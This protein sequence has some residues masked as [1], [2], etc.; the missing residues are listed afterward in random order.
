MKIENKKIC[1]FA[2]RPLSSERNLIG[3]SESSIFKKQVCLIS[4]ASEEPGS[5]NQLLVAR[6][7]QYVYGWLFIIRDDQC[8]NKQMLGLNLSLE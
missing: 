8:T 2:A 5:Y 7:S 1:P 3:D 4:K 6:G